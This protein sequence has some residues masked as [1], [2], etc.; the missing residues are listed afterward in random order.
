MAVNISSSKFSI[1][2]SQNSKLTIT[3]CRPT[4]NLEDEIDT[5]LTQGRTPQKAFRLN[6]SR[7]SSAMKLLG[8][9]HTTT[10]GET[11]ISHNYTPTTKIRTFSPV[12]AKTTSTKN[13][14][15]DK[16][17]LSPTKVHYR[18]SQHKKP[19]AV[20]EFESESTT[21]V[22][23][24]PPVSTTNLIDPKTFSS[25]VTYLNSVKKTSPRKNIKI[26][27]S[28]FLEKA[29]TESAGTESTKNTPTIVTIKKRQDFYSSKVT[30]PKKKP[31]LC[32]QSAAL[33]LPNADVYFKDLVKSCWDAMS[34]TKTQPQS[35]KF[36][37]SKLSEIHNYFIQN[38][39][40]MNFMSKDLIVERPAP[41]YYKRKFP[42][43][44]LLLL[45]L[46]ETL[47]HCNQSP[48]VRSTFD[49]EVD[50]INQE[51]HE[52]IGYLNIRPHVTR[53]LETMSQHYEVVIFT[54]SL[55]YYADRIVKIIDP[56]REYISEL[57]YRDSC[58]KTREQKHVKDLTIFKGIPLSDMILV[59]NNFYCLWPQPDNGV[60][61]MN[62]ENDKKDQELLKLEPFLLSLK[63]VKNHSTVI[64]N[65]FKVNQLALSST[66]AQYYSNF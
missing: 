4:P 38:H 31:V 44:K 33:N 55:K 45:D 49:M 19:T 63:E 50:F 54:A 64:R 22:L 6:M 29:D 37:I 35:N 30:S 25:A 28:T 36:S 40:T 57:F 9:N 14:L 58:S 52:L 5:P 26:G 51:G 24:T 10:T 61:I 7:S 60:P 27:L 46:D 48:S 17:K 2:A 32:Y 66:V 23:D 34:G 65:R 13:F 1:L 18:K 21:G 47:I 56:Q 12:K 15:L 41:I 39:K 11:N 59:D 43:R 16:T 62:F 53:F 20:S 42:D 8:L 3:V